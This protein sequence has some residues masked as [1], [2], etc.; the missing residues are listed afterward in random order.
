MK[1]PKGYIWKS[2]ADRHN[3]PPEAR[4]YKPVLIAPVKAPRAELV[5]ENGQVVAVS[6]QAQTF[7]GGG[8]RYY[9]SQY[10]YQLAEKARRI[11]GKGTVS[12]RLNGKVVGTLNPA[13]RAGSFR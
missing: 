2:H 12:L 9:F 3:T 1:L 4:A 8:W 10:G 7:N 6:S 13:F 11:H 5:T